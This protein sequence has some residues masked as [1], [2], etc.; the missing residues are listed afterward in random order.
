M[1]LLLLN[2]KQATNLERHIRGMQMSDYPNLALYNDWTIRSSQ[3]NCV[4]QIC[5]S[6]Q[7]AMEKRLR[8]DLIF[9]YFMYRKWFSETLV[10]RKR[11]DRM[12]TPYKVSLCPGQ[13]TEANAF[14]F[15]ITRFLSYF[16]ILNNSWRTSEVF[17]YVLSIIC[18]TY[19]LNFQ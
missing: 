12:M 18:T 9:N 16:Y 10:Q 8:Y 17:Y 7:C 13:Q 11:K 5:I 1:P 15:F 14:Y 3:M 6:Y 2:R 4:P 19:F